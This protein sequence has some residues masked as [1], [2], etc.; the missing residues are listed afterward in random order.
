[1][2]PSGWLWPVVMLAV[3]AALLAVAAGCQNVFVAKHRVLVDAI[4]APNVTKPTGVSY[5]L[6]AKKS[7]VTQAPGQPRIIAA[8]IDAALSTKGMYPAPDTVAPDIFIE[9]NYGVDQTPKIDAAQR[10]TFLQL[11]ARA[12]VDKSIDHGTGP[13]LWDV[14]VAVMGVAGRMETVMPVLSAVAA[15]YMG[16]DTKLE[17]R[18]EIP[19]NAPVIAAV[20]ES[21]IKI[22]ETKAIAEPA[23]AGAPEMTP[24][25]KEA[26]AA[27]AAKAAVTPVTIK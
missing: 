27:A 9:A 20:R 3:S 5:R 1:M 12:N 6:W 11:S 23:P 4:A 25:Q 21:A 2:K 18:I 13:E 19:Q 8:C 10:E 22:L 15:D 26:A 16:T 17:T 24:E 7:M 14:R